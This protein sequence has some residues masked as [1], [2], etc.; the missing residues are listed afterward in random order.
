MSSRSRRQRP[1][2]TASKAV[3][4]TTPNAEPAIGAQP[5][6]GSEQQTAHQDA[7]DIL[8]QA[9]ED[10]AK[11]RAEADEFRREAESKAARVKAEADAVAAR[12]VSLA[13]GKAADIATA[14]HTDATARTEAQV[15]A[16][17]KAARDTADQLRVQARE[18]AEQILDDAREAVARRRETAETVLSESRDRAVEILAE[19]E[20]R[21]KLIAVDAEALLKRAGTDAEQAATLRTEWEAKAKTKPR[22]MAGDD[23]EVPPLSSG[24]MVAFLVVILFSG[25]V[26]TLGLYSSFDTLAAKG[27]EWGFGGGFWILPDG[28]ILPTAI[29]I[30]IPA[31]TGANLFLIRK[32]MP[33]VWVRFVPWA[34]TLTT[35]YLNITAAHVQTPEELTAARIAHAVL[36]M[37]WVVLSEVA[38]HAYASFIGAVTGKRM[39]KIR[40]SRWFL[41][42]PSTFALWRRMVLW[43]ITSYQEALDTE[44]KR[45]EHADKLRE[46][47]GRW[48]RWKA[49]KSERFRHVRPGVPASPAKDTEDTVPRDTA[50]EDSAPEVQKDSEDAKD[51]DTPEGHQGHRPQG[52]GPRTS[53]GDKDTLQGQGQNL[54][55]APQGRPAGTDD[56]PKPSVPDP[57]TPNPEDATDQPKD[58]QGQGE[59][60][61]EGRTGDTPQGRTAATGQG[62]GDPH[63][64][65]NAED[66]KDEDGDPKRRRADDEDS[67]DSKDE[68]SRSLAHLSDDELVTLAHAL[69]GPISVR[70][71]ARE[72]HIGK[73][74]AGVIAKAAKHAEKDSTEDSDSDT[75]E[76]DPGNYNT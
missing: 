11:I 45:Q 72:F 66:T 29:D 20:R 31:F 18:E 32:K 69:K 6:A 55:D 24:E 36:P 73:D 35:C 2:V 5:D 27:A 33:L 68:D 12:I 26:G 25:A 57:R 3:S 1:K 60:Q 71:L 74:R 75:Q 23:G 59:G 65:G 30:G 14:A 54:G 40:A 63:E 76:S 44:S 7:A 70:R 49:P 61:A 67:K 34:G 9:E 28:W 8:R 53:L 16:S 62:Q 17:L 38:A 13:E 21:A 42:F 56:T 50:P 48:W 37:M 22:I 52:R 43:E 19:A 64:D 58:S 46:Q 15:T 51:R 47:Y 10:A 39:D 41:A 4:V